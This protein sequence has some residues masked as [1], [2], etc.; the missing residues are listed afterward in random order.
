MCAE[1][2]A[3]YP[4]RP[5]TGFS[6]GCTSSK[7]HGC[8]N[9]FRCNIYDTPVAD[10]IDTTMAWAVWCRVP[11]P[12]AT[13]TGT[14]SAPMYSCIISIHTFCEIACTGWIEH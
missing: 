12:S 4:E 6:F 7:S 2:T 9:N 13:A 8:S 10:T 11:P 5:C 14:F 1:W 3:A